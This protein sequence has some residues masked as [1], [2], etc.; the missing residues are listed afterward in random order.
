MKRH[1]IVSLV[2]LFTLTQTTFQRILL[3]GEEQNDLKPDLKD[4]ERNLLVVEHYENRRKEYEAAKC[5]LFFIYLLSLLIKN[6][7]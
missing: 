2:I 1:L 5:K 3:R 4:K 7:L 6:N